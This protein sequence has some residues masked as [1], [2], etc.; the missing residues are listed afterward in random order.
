[1]NKNMQQ[2]KKAILFGGKRKMVK[3]I[4]VFCFM[5]LSVWAQSRD[6]ICPP[7]KPLQ[8]KQGWCYACDNP[9][10]FDMTAME[11]AKCPN[12][13]INSAGRCAV[14]TCPVDQPMQDQRGWCYDCARDFPIETSYEMCRRCANRRML[15]NMCALKEC[16]THKPMQSIYGYCYPCTGEDLTD[17]E[18]TA[19]QCAKCPGRTFKEGRCV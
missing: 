14:K 10:A 17:V 4:F 11:C 1:M 19:D 18:M 2:L 7:D 16:P 12:R 8:D 6:K 3:W 5:T 15:H 9:Y 13:E